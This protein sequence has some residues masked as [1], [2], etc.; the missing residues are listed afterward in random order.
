MPAINTAPRAVS[1]GVTHIPD[2]GVGEKRVEA[3]T[4]CKTHRP[5]GVEAHEEAGQCR[6][7]TGGDKRSPLIHACRGHHL[8]I[9]KGNVGHSHKSGEACAQLDAN[10]GICL[11]KSEEPLHDVSL[12]LS[13]SWVGP[14]S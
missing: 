5:V 11:R 10:G 8:G 3:H 9:H 13:H 7:D 1:Q 14:F 4:R 12:L 2:D 6:G